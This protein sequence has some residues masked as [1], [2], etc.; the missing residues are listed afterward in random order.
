M[1]ASS[2]YFSLSP[3]HGQTP[4]IRSEDPV[5]SEK[6]AIVLAA[7]EREEN[8]KTYFDPDTE[9]ATAPE[10]PFLLY[11]AC[12]VGLAMV[13]VVFVEMLCVSVVC[14]SKTLGITTLRLISLAYHRISMGQR[15]DQVC[16]GK[17]FVI[18]DRT[19]TP[20]IS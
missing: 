7:I 17:N 14:I 8:A 11:H 18:S 16:T 3:A 5:I 20:V 2:P 15:N 4:S 1:T 10:R 12:V 13:L 9:A 6:N 19:T